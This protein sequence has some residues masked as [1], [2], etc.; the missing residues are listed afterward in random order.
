MRI[1]WKYKN[2]RFSAH[3]TLLRFSVE[4]RNLADLGSRHIALHR[5]SSARKSN[6]LQASVIYANK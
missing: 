3:E 5:V 2:D 4:C 6:F 1:A